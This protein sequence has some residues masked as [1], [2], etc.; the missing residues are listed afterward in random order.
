MKHFGPRASGERN[1]WSGKWALTAD[2]Q[3]AEIPVRAGTPQRR[4]KP[5]KKPLTKQQQMVTGSA[6]R[7]IQDA[8]LRYEVRN[9]AYAIM[10]EEIGDSLRPLPLHARAQ[11]VD[12]KLSELGLQDH[13]DW[14]WGPVKAGETFAVR[15]RPTSGFAGGQDVPM[16]F[17]GEKFTLPYDSLEPFIELV[18]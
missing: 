5:E 12:A 11:S 4:K 1:E 10:R 18:S 15:S 9:P 3:P 8:Q 16:L 13:R 17:G 2:V 6:W 14:L 7:V